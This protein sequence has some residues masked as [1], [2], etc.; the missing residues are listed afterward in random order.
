MTRPVPPKGFRIK[1]GKVQRDP[2]CLDASARA[3]L[4]GSKKVRIARR[5]AR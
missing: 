5:Q 3:R 4:R 1:N 2:K